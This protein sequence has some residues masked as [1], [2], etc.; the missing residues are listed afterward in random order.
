M[1]PTATGWLPRLR[2]HATSTA[3]VGV[4]ISSILLTGCL[5]HMIPNLKHRR[6]TPYLSTAA[7]TAQVPTTPIDIA[8]FV[9]FRPGDEVRYAELHVALN[10]LL[11]FRTCPLRLHFVVADD[12]TR[13][14]V[15]S[16]VVAHNGSEVDA[17]Y[18]YVR[19]PDRRLK[20][21]FQY[22][23]AVLKAVPDAILPGWIDRV[24]IVDFDMVWMRD[25][26]RA[27]D[28]FD[29]FGPKELVGLAVEQSTAYTLVDPGYG[30]QIPEAT[31]SAMGF[32]PHWAGLNSGTLF[33]NLQRMRAKGWSR[34]VYEFAA[35]LE[36][37]QPGGNHFK[38]GDQ[39]I[40]NRFARLHPEVVHVLPTEF[41]WCFD[42]ALECVPDEK[43]PE[44]VIAHANG[45]RL[46]AV[47]PDHGLGA[48]IANVWS[49]FT[50]ANMETIADDERTCRLHRVLTHGWCVDVTGSAC[51]TTNSKNVATR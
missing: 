3:Q 47:V 10:S 1:T 50:D 25:A 2:R 8:M 49:L 17:F 16:W 5:V 34:K 41:N 33:A 38:S 26:C 29:R 36:K 22:P 23:F 32:P 20:S 42:P 48:F 14:I 39:D 7:N 15:N 12:T 45:H 35:G 11:F 44:I 43:P 21:S 24:I 30:F 6:M 31:R 13:G 40:Y 28:E 9:R 46:H 27:F 51:Q 18:H 37:N 4:L 19:R